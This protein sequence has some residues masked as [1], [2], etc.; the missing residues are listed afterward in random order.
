MEP[1]KLQ[2]F[3]KNNI[4]KNVNTGTHEKIMYYTSNVINDFDLIF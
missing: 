1:S 2:N 3:N 4:N